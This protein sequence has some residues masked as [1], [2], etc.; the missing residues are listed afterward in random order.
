MCKIKSCKSDQFSFNER[1]NTQPREITL[2]EPQGPMN[3][4]QM[5]SPLPTIS[6]PIPVVNT[7]ASPPLVQHQ[8]KRSSMSQYS[9]ATSNLALHLLTS[10]RYSIH[11]ELMSEAL[12]MHSLYV[13][14]VLT[15]FCSLVSATAWIGSKRRMTAIADFITF[16]FKRGWIHYLV[17]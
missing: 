2:R 11:F 13:V 9:P 12:W 8:Y 4:C 15:R 16:L 14:G 1:I 10:S 3:R 5:G 17:F 6:I 7:T